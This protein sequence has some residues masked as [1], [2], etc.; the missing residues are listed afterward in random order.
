MSYNRYFTNEQFD[1]PGEKC[2]FISH[3]KKD[4]E[5]AK[6]IADYILKAGINI[7]FDEYDTSIDI[8]D[9]KSVVASIKLGCYACYR[10]TQWN[11]N[12]CHG[13]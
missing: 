10:I 4:K 11:R 7:Y 1:I 12:G 9:P 8:N 2:V 5:V 6:A 3:Q 13:K